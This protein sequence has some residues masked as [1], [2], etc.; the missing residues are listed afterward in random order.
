[1]WCGQWRIFCRMSIR[2]GKVEDLNGK[3]WISQLDYCNSYTTFSNYLRLKHGVTQPSHLDQITDG[4]RCKTLFCRQTSMLSYVLSWF[5]FSGNFRY[6]ITY[7][8]VNICGIFAQIRQS[9]QV[10]LKVLNEKCVQ[11]NTA[12]SNR[13]KDF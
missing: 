8:S 10:P 4:V 9:W 11:Q 12:S 2:F 7:K 3:V 6:T 13:S 1:M 5:C